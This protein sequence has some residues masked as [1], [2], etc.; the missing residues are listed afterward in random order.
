MTF[1]GLECLPT[2]W[3]VH[4]RTVPLKEIGRGQGYVRWISRRSLD[5]LRCHRS[6]NYPYLVLPAPKAGV[7]LHVCY[8]LNYPRNI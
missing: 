5:N 4:H 2:V 7:L 6:I 1:A 3:S 8:V